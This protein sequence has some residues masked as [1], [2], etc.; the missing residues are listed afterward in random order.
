MPVAGTRCF[1]GWREH[2]PLGRQSS[3]TLCSRTGMWGMPRCWPWDWP[4][5]LLRKLSP[6]VRRDRCSGWLPR[7]RVVLRRREW[8]QV[9]VKVGSMQLLFSEKYD[10]KWKKNYPRQNRN[11]VAVVGHPC[12]CRQ[13]SLN[14]KLRAGSVVLRHPREVR[15]N[16]LLKR[17]T[18]NS[19][20][21]LDVSA[22]HFRLINLKCHPVSKLRRTT[23]LNK[24][25]I[26][27]KKIIN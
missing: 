11:R 17:N 9:T 25:I 22:W 13:R 26:F 19:I 3:F 24:D 20:V 15:R 18:A 8:Q 10:S 4:G 1:R 6:S 23:Y 27:K 5:G 21:T 16:D 12:C 14:T 2:E 7:W